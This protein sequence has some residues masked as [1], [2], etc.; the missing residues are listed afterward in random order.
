MTLLGEQLAAVVGAGDV[1]SGPDI[2]DDYS[3]DE[4]L[5]ATAVR[6]TFVV[7]PQTTEQVAAIVALAADHRVALT[8]RGSGTG[9]CGACIPQP[10]GIVVSFERM[11]AILEIDRENFVAVVQPGVTL[12]AARR[13]DGRG[14]SHLS[15]LPG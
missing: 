9:L 12:A 5:T 6:P 13:G 11:D 7:R 2:S 8:A 10:G 1:L 15:R 3:H 4:A 14:R